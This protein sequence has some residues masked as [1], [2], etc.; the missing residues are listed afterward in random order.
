[1]V[2]LEWVVPESQRDAQVTAIEIAGGTVEDSGET[3][4]P[5][6]EEAADYLAAGLEPL[7]MIVAAGSVVFVAEALM[8]MWRNRHAQGGVVVDARG[9]KLRVRPVPGLPSG[10]LVVIDEAGARVVDREEENAGRQLL[11]DVVARFGK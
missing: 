7:T 1:M 4:Q 10:R 9:G 8:K 6:R 3:Y 11:S 2:E 5:T